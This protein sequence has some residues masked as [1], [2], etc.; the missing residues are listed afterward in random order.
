MDYFR[1]RQG[2]LFCEEVSV[3]DLAATH[4][5]PLYVYSAR[6]AAE[7]YRKVRDAFS[8]V[9]TLVCYSIKAN[10]NLSICNLLRK[11]GAGF[12]VV[13]EGELHR[14][15]AVGADPKTC[16]F[17]GVGK[18]EDEVRFALSK[19]IL[20]FNVE[21]ADELRLVDRV[22][23]EMGTVAPVAFRLNP[24]VDPQTHK[25][26]TTGKRE[27]KFGIDLALAASLARAMREWKGVR[28]VGLHIH[29]GS[30][31]LKVEPYVKSVMKVVDFLGTCREM[32]H[33]IDLLN[34]GGGFGIF[35]KEKTARP[36][37]E[38]ADAI[39][40]TVAR[41]GCRLL[42][43]PGRFVVGN[44][45]ILLT[46]VQFVKESGDLRFIICD[47]GMNDLI[48]PSL[49]G[50]YHRIWP[51][52]TDAS[53]EGEPPDEDLWTGETI[54]TEVVGPICESGDFFAHERKLPRIHPGEFVAVFS[55]GAYGYTMASNYNSHRR[56]AEVL[57]SGKDAALVTQRETYE[58][59]MRNERIVDVEV[60]RS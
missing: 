45:G 14:V 44:A 24:D 32:G 57:V 41:S 43:E 2:R 25:Y 36:V 34:I 17:A 53:Y 18:R 38:F 19:G 13:S 6:T 8:R 56:P 27:N 23:R 5:T 47:A 59:L 26:I 35:Y 54:S 29:I 46:T 42:L 60:A 49:Y 58:D 48:R 12:D 28:L 22:A 16:V 21:S 40:P 10:S 33:R 7:H 1:Y 20:L 31:I 50:A 39:T 37:S 3:A 4:G 9:P 30:Q 15:L 52:A 51:A 11:E 55:A